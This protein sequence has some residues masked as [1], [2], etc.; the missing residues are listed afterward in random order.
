MT[1]AVYLFP[2]VF[3]LVFIVAAIRKVKAYESFA[4]GIKG[5]IPL[6][7]SLFPYIAAVNVL[8]ALFEASGLSAKL[9]ELLSPAFSF[10]GIPPEICRLV[11][12]KPFSGSGSA[13]ILADIFSKYGADSY[14]SRC[15]GVVYASGET[16]FYMSAVYFAGL[17]KKAPAAAVGIAVLS[18]FIAIVAGCLICRI[19]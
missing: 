14:I 7:L 2:V 10:I 9:T 5:A 16:V 6:I 18:N 15:A 12:I 1:F 4:E 8:A 19:L 11:L 17:G 3:L 13:A